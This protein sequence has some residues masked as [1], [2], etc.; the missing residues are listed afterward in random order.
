[1]KFVAIVTLLVAMMVGGRVLAEDGNISQSDL[2]AFGLGGMQQVSDTEG[3]QVRGMASFTF[4]AGASL[5]A[6]NFLLGGDSAVGS[7]LF[8]TGN[9]DAGN[10]GSTS[11]VN[12]FS[13]AD[14]GDFSGPATGG[15]IGYV[16]SGSAFLPLVIP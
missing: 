14:S 9:A 13:V 15:N 8:A 6:D 2:A 3:M 7:N 4:I 5:A 16:T 12:L 11:I 1:M 10:A